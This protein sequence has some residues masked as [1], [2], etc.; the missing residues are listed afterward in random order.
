MQEVDAAEAAGDIEPWQKESQAETLLQEEPPR[1]AIVSEQKVEAFDG[2][3]LELSNGMRVVYR[4]SD[5]ME[6][7]IIMSV[8]KR[9]S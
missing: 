7:Q 3:E 5:L 6:D 4:K 2:T 1:G 9:P 8:R